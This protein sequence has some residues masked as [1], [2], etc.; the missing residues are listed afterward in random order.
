MYH[1]D[2]D[3]GSFYWTPDGGFI[4]HIDVPTN[5]RRRGAATDMYEIAKAASAKSGV[6]APEHSMH[7]TDEGD[8]WAKKVGGQLPERSKFLR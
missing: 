2:Q 5:I 3:K 1:G 8:A 7:R 6:D 4:Q